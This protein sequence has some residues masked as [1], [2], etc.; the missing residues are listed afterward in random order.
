VIDTSVIVK[1]I[2]CTHRGRLP[3]PLFLALRTGLA[4]GFM[5]HHT[6]AE[7]PRILARRAEKEH[8]DLAALE[9]LWWRSYVEVIRFAPTG[10]LPPPDPDLYRELAG[11]DDTDLPTLKLAS[12]LAPVV[13]LA[14]DRDLKDIG[15]AYEQWQE[16]PEAVQRIIIAQGSTELAARA[17]FGTGY[18]TV[19]AVRGATRALQRPA[20]AWTVLGIIAIAYMTRQWWY[21]PVKRRIQEASPQI[22]EAAGTAGR[23]IGGWLAQYGNALTVWSSAQRGK[24]GTTMTHRLARMLATSPKPMTRTEITK[25]LP[26]AIAR[27]GHRPVMAGLADIL[28]RHQAFCEISRH[29]WQLGKEN[30]SFGGRAIPPGHPPP[31]P[32]PAPM[33]QTLRLSETPIQYVDQSGGPQKHELPEQAG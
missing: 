1:D 25:R 23:A 9:S 24:P 13:V 32:K 17:L 18:G 12:L 3:S 20:V 15:L 6:W 4:R 11:R 7:V 10:D 16:V 2:I 27:H 33:L 21:P 14:A 30:A 19:I 31:T 22:R 28:R 29:R 5:A 8:I 26:D